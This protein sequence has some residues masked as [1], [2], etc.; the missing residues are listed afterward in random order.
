M[1]LMVCCAEK[2]GCGPAHHH[3][4]SSTAAF[5]RR[6]LWCPLGRLM[7][8]VFSSAGRTAACWPLAP[9]C[10]PWLLAEGTAA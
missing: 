10:A 1:V 3:P 9:T 5:R 8:L 7:G 4:V 2:V 6:W